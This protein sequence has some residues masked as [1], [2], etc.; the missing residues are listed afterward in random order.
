MNT[1]LLTLLLPILTLGAWTWYISWKLDNS[2]DEI[3]SLRET[4]GTLALECE[5]LGSKKIKVTR[6]DPTKEH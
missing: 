1:E 6:H 5:A 2:Y 3:D 4:V